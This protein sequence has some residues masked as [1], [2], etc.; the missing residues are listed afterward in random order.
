MF[1][2]AVAVAVM[3]AN[4]VRDCDGQESSSS[5][6]PASADVAGCCCCSCLLLLLLSLRAPSVLLRG[7]LVN[8]TYGKHKNLNIYLFLLTLFGPIYYGPLITHT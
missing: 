4:P 6:A 5:R 8:R 3:A 1:S 2:V 7:T